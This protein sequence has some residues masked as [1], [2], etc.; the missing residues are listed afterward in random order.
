VDV[1]RLN[2][3]RDTAPLLLLQAIDEGRLVLDRDDEWS[4]L[5]RHRGNI[6]QRARDAHASRRGRAR[7]SVLEL[8]SNE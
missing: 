7:A 4:E 2:R 3:V 8:L 1:A 6:A 5:S